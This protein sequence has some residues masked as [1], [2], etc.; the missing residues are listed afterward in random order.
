MN[1]YV[2]HYRYVKF[3]SPHYKQG[4]G[5]HGAAYLSLLSLLSGT[6]ILGYASWSTVGWLVWELVIARQNF[7]SPVLGDVLGTSTTA[8]W[9][10]GVRVQR[11]KTGFPAFTTSWQPEQIELSEF[12]LSVPKLSIADAK[13]AVSSLDFLSSLAHFPGTALPGQEGN[14]F[15]SGH[16]V[17]PQFYNPKDYQTIFSTLPTLSEEDEIIA[18]VAGLKYRYTV[19]KKR[20]VDPSDVSVLLPPHPTGKYLTLM[21]CVP[22]GLNSK[23]LVVIAKLEG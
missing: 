8:P 17:L 19:F 20:V 1:A 9:I 6:F 22:P 3:N 16:S 11:L 18:K 23:R 10:S 14:V 13:V 21:T 7:E 12:S 4:G 15:I 2:V 5:W